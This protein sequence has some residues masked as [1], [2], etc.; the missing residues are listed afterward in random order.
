[1]T[2]RK[3]EYLVRDIPFEMYTDHEN[4]VYLNNSPSNK[5]LRWKLAIQEYDFTLEHIKGDLN[6]VSDGFSV[7]RRIPQ[8]QRS[9][10]QKQKKLYLTSVSLYCTR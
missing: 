10:G 3:F 5:V 9:V 2:L 7:L 6:V 4:L 8:R 1:M